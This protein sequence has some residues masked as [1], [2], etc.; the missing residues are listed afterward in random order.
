MKEVHHRV[1]SNLQPVISLLN[2]QTGYLKDE[3]ALHRVNAHRLRELSLERI[4]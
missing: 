4:G 1:K 3:L 2:M